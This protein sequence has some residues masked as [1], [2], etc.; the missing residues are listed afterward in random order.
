[1][2]AQGWEGK[3]A[4]T[5]GWVFLKGLGC[6]VQSLGTF[7]VWRL[8]R[9]SRR[10]ERSDL[11]P[12][13]EIIYYFNREPEAEKATK[14]LL[15]WSRGWTLRGFTKAMVVEVKRQEQNEKDFRGRSHCK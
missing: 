9:V 4:H 14:R 3:E 15:Q 13:K 1:M 11:F 8:Q 10:V 2:G 6:W 7:A 12:R 5:T